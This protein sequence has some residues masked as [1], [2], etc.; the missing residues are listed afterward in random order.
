MDIFVIDPNIK[1]AAV[2]YNRGKFPI[3][4]GFTIMSRSPGWWIS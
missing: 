2:Y 1:L 3:C 4:S